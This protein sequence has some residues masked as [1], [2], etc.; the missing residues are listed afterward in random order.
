MIERKGLR[1]DNTKKLFGYDSLAFFGKVSASISHELKNVMAIISETAG[2][3]GDLS[4]MAREGTAVDPDMLASSTDSIIEEIQRG[5]TT[6]RQMNRFA[7]SVDTPVVSVDLMEILEL[8]INLSGYLS[9][10]GKMDLSPCEGFTPMAETS[11][12]LLQA[13]VYETLVYTFKHS[14]PDTEISISIQSTNA[15]SWRIIFSGFT[16]SEFHVFPDD[17]TKAMAA[18]IGVII[19]A[20]RSADHLDLEVPSRIES[21]AANPVSPEIPNIGNVSR[22]QT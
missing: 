16:F 18:S 6:I 4:E 10:S 19:H 8:T 20:D 7:H 1:M 9:F 5:F 15:S 14:G 3:L 17:T 12:F 21:L 11:P 2:L 22:T 13:I